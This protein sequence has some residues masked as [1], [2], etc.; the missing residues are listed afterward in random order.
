VTCNVGTLSPGFSSHASITARVDANASVG[1]VLAFSAQATLD[2]VDVN[3]NNEVVHVFNV[4]PLADLYVDALEDGFL[5]KPDINHG[6][7]ICE[8]E[9]GVCTLRAAIDESN[10]MPGQQVV[11]L[12]SGVYTIEEF[13]SLELTD[14][15][16]LIGNGAPQSII[17]GFNGSS[18]VFII[19][20]DATLRIENITIARGRI[21]ANDGNLVMRRSRITGGVADGAVGGAINA[22]KMIDIRDTLIDGNRAVSGG[23]IWS[24]PQG[25]TNSIL[26][27]ITI[28]GNQGGGLYLGAGSYTLNHVTINVNSRDTG[29]ASGISGG[30]LTVANS[31]TATITGSILA[32]NYQPPGLLDVPFNCTVEGTAA[33]NSNG[34]NI[35]G[36]LTGCN[37]ATQGSDIQIVDNKA[38]LS[39]L[40]FVGDTVPYIEPRPDSPAIDAMSGPGCPAKDARDL[41]RPQ[42]GD[43][44]GSAICDIGAVEYLPPQIQT[45]QA[46]IDFGDIP[47]GTISMPTTITITN[48]GNQDITIDAI[49]L[50]GP[51][52][53]AFELPILDDQCTGTTLSSNQ[54]CQFEIEFRPNQE[55]LYQAAVKISEAS[56]APDVIVELLGS[57]GIIFYNC[58]E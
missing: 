58:F 34:N 26:E 7:G 44:N 50:I 25:S 57:S 1:T 27:N 23:A 30:A 41:I 48:T 4:V 31:A 42:D 45:S 10:A 43:G 52:V 6:D 16:V 14:D 33:L 54:Q 49:T 51:D 15:L 19:S 9:D 28:T 11:S 38:K 24:W 2:Q 53:E 8:S 3:P 40:K 20:N 32:G 13:I 12:G 35:L 21:R 17:D 18:Y 46:N 56:Q 47:V 29:G 37:I 22:G 55:G 36:N 5:D 39:P